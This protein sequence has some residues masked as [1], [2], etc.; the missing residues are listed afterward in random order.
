MPESPP[1]A[2]RP[3]F[4]ISEVPESSTC[5]WC[6][7]S[8][9]DNEAW[10]TEGAREQARANATV[11]VAPTLFS[12][13]I[14]AEKRDPSASRRTVLR[15]RTSNQRLA[16]VFDRLIC[17]AWPTLAGVVAEVTVT[18][19]SGTSSLYETPLA[20]ETTAPRTRPGHCAA[21]AT[22]TGLGHGSTLH[23]CGCGLPPGRGLTFSASGRVRRGS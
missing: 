14:I 17:V 6:A 20:V 21:L 9:V 12:R 3:G 19:V 4:G 18:E 8:G 13:I 11:H 2:S 15:D 5:F 10:P 22:Q 23:D 16:R 7:R 1:P